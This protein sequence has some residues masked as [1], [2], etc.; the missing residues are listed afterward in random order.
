MSSRYYIHPEQIVTVYWLD[1]EGMSPPEIK[2]KTD[3]PL[4]SV[5]SILRVLPI[6]LS[7]KDKEKQRHSKNYRLALKILKRDRKDGPQPKALQAPQTSQDGSH[8]AALKEAYAAFEQAAK[9]YVQAE[10][11]IKH[12]ALLRENEE[13][14]KDVARLKEQHSRLR[15]SWIDELGGDK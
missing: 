13:L 14:K 9:A 8:V 11:A 1:Q 15:R 3:M 4:S 7:G 12:A 10:A 2:A 5:K 6:Y